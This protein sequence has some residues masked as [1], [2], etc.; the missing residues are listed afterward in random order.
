MSADLEAMVS[1]YL[2]VRRA[3][4]YRNTNTAIHHPGGLYATLPCSAT[5]IVGAA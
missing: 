2:R 4:K 5:N 1:D 3:T